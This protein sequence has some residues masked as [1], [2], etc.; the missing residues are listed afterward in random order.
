ME[1][2]YISGVGTFSHMHDVHRVPPTR[3]RAQAQATLIE[4]STTSR[5]LKQTTPRRRAHVILFQHTVDV[6]TPVS[7]CFSRLIVIGASIYSARALS[8]RN[9]IPKQPTHH[10]HL[11][12]YALS[13]WLVS[14]VLF[15]AFQM[16]RVGQSTPTTSRACI[17]HKDGSRVLVHPSLRLFRSYQKLT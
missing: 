3:Q 15:T 11:R 12:N 4:A 16:H 9:S 1:S 13:C 10:I 8:D 6:Q 5:L 17:A 14:L 7:I 2:C